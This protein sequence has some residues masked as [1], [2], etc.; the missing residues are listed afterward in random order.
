[1]IKWRNVAAV[2]LLAGGLVALVGCNPDKPASAENDWTCLHTGNK[3]CTIDG[4]QV[5][6]LEGM[7]PVDYAYE[8]CVFLLKISKRVSDLAYTDD[9]CEPLTPQKKPLP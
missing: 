3:A 9:I 2:A 6:S 8:R 4:V 1:M 7:P 5:V